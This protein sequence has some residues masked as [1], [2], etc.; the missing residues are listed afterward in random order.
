[1]LLKVFQL[2]N[3]LFRVRKLSLEALN[4]IVLGSHDSGSYGMT[5]SSDLSP[6]AEEILQ[7]LQFLGSLLKGIM[8][9]WSRTQE[10]DVTQQL[11]NGIRYFDLR[12]ATKESEA[13]FYFVHGLYA[14]EVGTFMN[15]VNSFLN[16][17]SS[18]V[19]TLMNN[20]ERVTAST[21]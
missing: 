18:E 3:L 20:I 10:S 8:Y 9:K 2:L 16:A 5:T 13:N 4:K 6:D 12:T 7:E 1:M 19:R 14:A 17:H 11:N 15:A 21:F